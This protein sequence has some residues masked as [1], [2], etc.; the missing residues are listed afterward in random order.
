MYTVLLVI[1]TIFVLFM[2]M[3]VLIQRTDSDGLGGL[4]GGGGNQFMTGRAKANFMTRTTA[5]LAGLFMTTSLILAVMASHMTSGSIVDSV[6]TDVPKAEDGAVMEK[7]EVTVEKKD[8]TVVEKKEV[9][10]EK[11]EAPAPV[12]AAPAK[13]APVVPKPE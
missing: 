9:T 6:V 11:K 2:I 3:F 7:K 12:K 10:T 1:H 8:G 5:I 4:S 13:S